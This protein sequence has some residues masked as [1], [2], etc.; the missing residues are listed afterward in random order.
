MINQRNLFGGP[1]VA[2][3]RK[4]PP[5]LEHAVRVQ[6]FDMRRYLP[7]EA[8]NAGFDLMEIRAQSGPGPVVLYDRWGDILYIWPENYMPRQFEIMEM[9]QSLLWC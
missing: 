7:T 4:L 6:E 1:P 9:C 3:G 5:E 2:H 8:L